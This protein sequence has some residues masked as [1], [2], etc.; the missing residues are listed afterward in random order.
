MNESWDFNETIARAVA[1]E[2]GLPDEL[3]AE[4]PEILVAICN[5]LLLE[6]R[7]CH[8]IA[9]SWSDWGAGVEGV[10]EGI[11]ERGLEVAR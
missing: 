10:M 4:V 6:R 2:A 7:V 5:A 3:V 8:D 11:A 9:E 1:Q